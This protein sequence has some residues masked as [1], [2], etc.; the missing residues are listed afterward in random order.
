MRAIDVIPKGTESFLEFPIGPLSEGTC[1]GI[2]CECG[3]DHSLG[4]RNYYGTGWLCQGK[5]P[6]E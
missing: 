5:P 6:G 2:E 3:S 1:C 4:R